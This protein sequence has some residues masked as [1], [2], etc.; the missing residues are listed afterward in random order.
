MIIER[1]KVKRKMV[2]C[3]FRYEGVTYPS[4]IV[5]AVLLENGKVLVAHE[6]IGIFDAELLPVDGFVLVDLDVNSRNYADGDSKLILK[7]VAGAI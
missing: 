6:G 4:D 7:M 1:K 2:N 3:I 5:D